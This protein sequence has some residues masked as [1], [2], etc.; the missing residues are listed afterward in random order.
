VTDEPRLHVVLCQPEIPQNTGNIGRTCLATG[1]KLWLVRP[2][3]FKL[4]AKHLRRAGLDYWKHL[5][6]ESVDDWPTLCTRLEPAR[7][8]LFTKTAA[9]PYTAVRY[10]PGDILVFGR[11]TQG[12]PD[13]LLARHPDRCVRIPIRSPV[14]SL[15]L[16]S[17]VAVAVY[18]VVRQ[19]WPLDEPP[20][21][22]P[23]GA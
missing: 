1:A 17:A 23:G 2:L 20:A 13:S 5:D 22:A 4:D 21:S 14:R 6:C 7:M 19:C 16:S 3:G 8:W 10:Q 15:N 11:E 12:L 18:E 9:Q